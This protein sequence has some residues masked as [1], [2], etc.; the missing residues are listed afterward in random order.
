MASKIRM[1]YQWRLFFPLIGLLWL[2]LGVTMWWHYRQED[3][4]RME[5]VRKQMDYINSRILYERDMDQD[6]FSLFRFLREYFRG[7]KIFEDMRISVYDA[8]NG[9]LIYNLGI[10]IPF[11]P[12]DRYTENTD[13]IGDDGERLVSDKKGKSKGREKSLYYAIT[14]SDDDNVVIYSAVPL[15]NSVADALLPDSEMWI[16]LILMALA[17]SAVAYGMTRYV[18]SNIKTMRA[19]ATQAAHNQDFIPDDNFSH[20]ELG[21]INRQIVHIFNERAKAIK[22]MQREHELTLRTIEEKNAMKRR[23]TNNVSHELKTPVCIVKGYLDTIVDNPDMDERSRNHFMRKAQENINRMDTL[24]KDISTLNRFDD[25]ADIIP[26]ELLDFHDVVM[27]VEA[28]AQESGLMRDMTLVN[29]VPEGTIIKGNFSLLVA[30]LHNLLKNAVAY[31]QGTKVGVRLDSDKSSIYHFTF[32]DN[33][34]GVAPE[35]LEHL[36]ERFYCVDS[37]RSR[38]ASGTGLGLPIVKDTVEF[39]KGTIHVSN[40]AEGGLE[41]HFSIPKA[42]PEDNA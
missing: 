15:S 7:D 12:D 20:D 37:G 3:D 31:S 39:H 25:G 10:P 13:I 24:I 6:V 26:T 23:M 11:D 28:E 8:T 1:S 2:L 42:S 34:V 5:Q 41:F 21:D 27:T 35:H 38:K 9:T 30:M 32:F 18:G 22:D 29:T 16:T 17:I 33:G 19:F 4:M 36:F 40:A 14:H